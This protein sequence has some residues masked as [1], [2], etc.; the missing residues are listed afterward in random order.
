MCLVVC[1]FNDLV[2]G[3]NRRSSCSR[4]MQ[5]LRGSGQDAGWPMVWCPKEWCLRAGGPVAR[6]CKWHRQR[7]ARGATRSLLQIIV[8]PFFRVGSYSNIYFLR[9]KP[10]RKLINCFRLPTTA[11]VRVYSCMEL[12]RERPFINFF[13]F[14]VPKKYRPIIREVFKFPVVFYHLKISSSVIEKNNY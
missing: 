11:L 14:R 2:F 6:V 13:S 5:F 12:C 7:T 1:T 8:C 4:R 3:S 9:H 10:S